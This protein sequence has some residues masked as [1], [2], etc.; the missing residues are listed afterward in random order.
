LNDSDDLYETELKKEINDEIKKEKEINQEIENLE[1]FHDD[2]D[3]KKD[4]ELDISENENLKSKIADKILEDEEI[5][6]QSNQIQDQTKFDSMHKELRNDEDLIN[7]IKQNENLDKEI[8]EDLQLIK[9]AERLG[10]T[11]QAQKIRAELEE[12]ENKKKELLRKF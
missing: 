11:E 9:D 12:L 10:L 6:I 3:L 7:E 8:E 4:I 1:Q 2:S 5:E